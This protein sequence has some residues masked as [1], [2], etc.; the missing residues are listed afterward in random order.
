[1]VQSQTGRQTDGQKEIPKSPPCISTGGLKNA[2][3]VFILIRLLFKFNTLDY[4]FV[5]PLRDDNLVSISPNVSS[6]SRCY[7]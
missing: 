1:M 3:E 2:N 7:I 4:K 5:I 6:F